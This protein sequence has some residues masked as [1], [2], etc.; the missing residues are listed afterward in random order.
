MSRWRFHRSKLRNPVKEQAPL[1][2]RIITRGIQVTGFSSILFVLLILYFLISEGA[3]AFIEVPLK[4]LAAIRWYPIENYF[5][6]V[7][8]ILG[9]LLVTAG[10]ALI[11][12]VRNTRDTP[13]FEIT[14]TR[15][16]AEVTAAIVAQRYQPVFK[17][18]EATL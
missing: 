9:S 3:P 16:V 5:G 13:Q 14:D 15:S 10:A 7:S 17:D 2:E 6:I 8:L 4:D 18:W 12:P 11:E 1:S